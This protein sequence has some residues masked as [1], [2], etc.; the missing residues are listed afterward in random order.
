MFKRVTLTL[1]ILLLLASGASAQG[2]AHNQAQSLLHK[3]ELS[4]GGAFQAITRSYGSFN[5]SWH[6][7][8]I[9]IRC[10][11]FVTEGF[12]LEAETIVAV[13][14]EG[15]LA[16]GEDE[17]IIVASGNLVYNF[18]IKAAP[19]FRPFVLGGLGFT[20]S[21]LPGIAGTVLMNDANGTTR[22]V[23][24]FGAGAKTLL[25]DRA[26]FRVEYRFQHFPEDSTEGLSGATSHTIQL[27]VSM[28]L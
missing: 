19:H 9:P 16:N 18:P 25:G 2:P 28:F 20:N 21:F 5:Q 26:A 11:Y 1:V 12:E 22:L 23:T 27:G 24:N 17:F 6:F 3:F 15:A 7:F 4:V 13:L 14:Q 8:N 10:G